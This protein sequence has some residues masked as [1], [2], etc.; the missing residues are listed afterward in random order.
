M[1]PLQGPLHLYARRT[2]GPLSP[3]TGPSISS[4]PG[5]L[6]PTTL[7]PLQ[8]QPILS[9]RISGLQPPPLPAIPSINRPFVN[10]VTP[11]T[12]SD[13]NI[14]ST[15]DVDTEG[16]TTTSDGGTKPLLSKQVTQRPLTLLRPRNLSIGTMPL[17]PIGQN[18]GRPL[19]PFSRQ[20]SV[21]TMPLRRQSIDPFTQLPVPLLSPSTTT[22]RL[23]IA[24]QPLSPSARRT[25]ALLTPPVTG[26]LRPPPLPP[27]TKENTKET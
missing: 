18:P 21:P 10:K 24:T 8:D 14:T 25:G 22:P 15:S 23:P 12:S 7:P 4:I 9:R 17:P 1:K 27:I 2:S 11:I 20:G 5:V 3:S 13:E 26:S 6:R 19:A 16:A